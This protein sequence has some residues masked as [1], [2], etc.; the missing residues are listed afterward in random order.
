MSTV[1]AV[2]IPPTRRRIL[3]LLWI[4]ILLAV[5]GGTW[6]AFHGTSAVVAAKGSNEQFLAWNKRQPGVVETESGLQYQIIKPGEGPALPTGQVPIVM[7][8]G[9][10]RD[11]TTFDQSQRPVPMPPQ[12]MVKGFGEGLRL[13]PKGAQYR[14]WMK[15]ELAYGDQ[16]PDP[17]R[18][19][20]G[21]LLIF[22]V[23]VTE[24]VSEQALMQQMMQQ[25]AQGGTNRPR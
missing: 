3:I 23:A 25:Q 4:G 20:P 12:A 22:D 10:L 11:G 17:T 8:A 19:P 14:F 7:Y 24:F 16:S 2:P 18:V 21:S 9:H 6:L 1:T 13:M 5:A 15:P